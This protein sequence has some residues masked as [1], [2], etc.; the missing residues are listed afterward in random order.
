MTEPAF[1]PPILSY[2]DINKYAEDFLRDHNIDDT[3]P[4]P[5]EEIVDVH[6]KID[7]VPFPDL[8]RNF[9]IE[10]FISRDFKSIYVDEY[11][12]NNRITRYYFTLAHEIG[13]YV[14]HKDLIER[15]RPSSVADWKDFIHKVDDESYGWLEYQAYAFAGLVLVPRKSLYKHFSSQ[16]K[17]IEHK[18]KFAKAQEFPK[19]TYQEYVIE[20]IAGNLTGMYDVSLS[21]LKRRI[22]K[23]VEIGKLHIP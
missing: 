9:D 7:I 16:L 5:I 2:E 4:V 17:D 3:L 8:Q 15:I 23:E 10:G 1:R 19:D 11:I 22:S 14:I 20:A 21:A 6:L 12:Y 13:H 18:I